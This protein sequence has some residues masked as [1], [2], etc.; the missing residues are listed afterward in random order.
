MSFKKRGRKDE[1]METRLPAGAKQQIEQPQHCK[2]V[3]EQQRII[4]LTVDESVAL[5]EMM[6]AEPQ[7]NDKAVAAIRRYRKTMGA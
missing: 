2:E 6:L 4:R 5:A 7:A 3:I 1:R